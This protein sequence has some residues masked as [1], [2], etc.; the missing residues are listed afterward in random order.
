VDKISLDQLPTLFVKGH[1][2]FGLKP[3]VGEGSF[4][5]FD[6][7]EGLQLRFWDCRFTNELEIVTNSDKADGSFHLVFFLNAPGLNLLTDRPIKRNRIWDTAFFSSSS[8]HRI[9]I[10]PVMTVQCLSLSFSK[11]W[12][13]QILSRGDQDVSIIL[14]KHF[15]DPGF[16]MLDCMNLAE[17]KNVFE[18]S[19]MATSEC[20][21]SFYIKSAVLK[22]IGDFFLK[23]VEDKALD[24]IYKK[25]FKTEE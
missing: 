5:I 7:E 25:H 14:K 4:C 19:A 17:K 16:C 20:I 8:N 11:E 18:L 6:I 10:Q 2:P 22:I 15:T 9:V 21:A 1:P 13:N 23:L 3:E 24:S 12:L